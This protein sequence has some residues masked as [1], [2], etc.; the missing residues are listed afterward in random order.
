MNRCVAGVFAA[1]V[2]GAACSVAERR[3]RLEQ[4]SKV[5]TRC[6][7]SIGS[8]PANYGGLTFKWGDPN[9]LMLGGAANSFDG[10][11]YS[12]P[13]IR[14]K[15]GHITGF[16]G[17]GVFYSTASQID[18]GL[19]YAPN[20]VLAFVTYSNN[21]IGQIRDGDNA[22]FATKTSPSTACWAPRG[23]WFLFPPTSPAPA[24]SRF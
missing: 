12:V 13:L 9:T 11:V 16:A 7:T 18:G 1:F 19:D 10:A 24:A 14:D 20:G 6:L 22:P 2:A 8:G 3:R 17:P 15:E 23:A 21:A 5:R 4:R